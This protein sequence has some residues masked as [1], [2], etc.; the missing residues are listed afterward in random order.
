MG[1][2][3]YPAHH[4]GLGAFIAIRGVTE[5]DTDTRLETLGTQFKGRVP[6]WSVTTFLWLS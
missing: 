1:P 5:I 4:R 6:I 3:S 2:V